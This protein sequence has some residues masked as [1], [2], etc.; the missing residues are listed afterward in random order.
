MMGA[1][2]AGFENPETPDIFRELAKPAGLLGIALTRD[3]EAGIFTWER[4]EDDSA[5]NFRAVGIYAHDDKRYVLDIK[6]ERNIGE[7]PGT[8]NRGSVTVIDQSGTLRSISS[9]SSGA[10]HYFDLVRRTVKFSPLANWSIGQ[11]S[12]PAVQQTAR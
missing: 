5:G 4:L 8:Q 7:L 9:S 11:Q 2:L 12:N 3:I 1:L 10:V 6:G